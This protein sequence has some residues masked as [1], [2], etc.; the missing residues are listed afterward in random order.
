M[1]QLG[2]E[3]DESNL[4]DDYE[5]I[6]TNWYTAIIIASEMKENK[7]RNGSYLQLSWQIVEGQYAGRT[8]FDR[9]NLNNQ[10][11]DAVRIARQALDK[12][13]FATGRTTA[14]DSME[15]HN[16][17]VSIRVKIQPAKGEW[18]ASNVVGNYKPIGQGNEQQQQSGFQQPVQQQHL[19][20]WHSQKPPLWSKSF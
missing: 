5:V 12:I 1:A 8:I 17:P 7:A 4:R 14:R 15:L 10:N 18:E 2:Y 11:Q 13:R 6:P 3:Y 9:L 16:I 19:N 20:Q